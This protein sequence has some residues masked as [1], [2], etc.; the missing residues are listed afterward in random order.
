MNALVG[1]AERADARFDVFYERI[2]DTL[3]IVAGMTTD[4]A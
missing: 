3:L 1:L 4:R 2:G